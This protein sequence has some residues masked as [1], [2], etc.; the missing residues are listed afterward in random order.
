M[1]S[2]FLFCGSWG[3]ELLLAA[4]GPPVVIAVSDC[5][6]GAVR[7]ITAGCGTGGS[8]DETGEVGSYPSGCS[9]PGGSL[10]SGKSSSGKGVSSGSLASGSSSASKM[11][12]ADGGG[13]IKGGETAGGVCGSG[14]TSD[15]G[16]SNCSGGTDLSTS[17]CAAGCAAGEILRSVGRLLDVG[18]LDLA[19]RLIVES[20]SPNRWYCNVWFVT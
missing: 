7:S 5:C 15:C 6:E 10:R 16:A 9:S 18:V 17:S 19:R 1:A 4:C 8:S 14:S 3:S 20:I 13:G 11:V 2:K 12:F